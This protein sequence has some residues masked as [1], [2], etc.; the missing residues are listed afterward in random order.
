MSDGRL[1]AARTALGLVALLTAVGG[2]ARFVALGNQS[3]WV[4]ETVTA[5]LVAGSFGELLSALPT[6]ESTPPLYYLLAWG[7]ANVLGSGEAALRS[8]S[9]VL[10]TAMVPVVFAAGRELV[11]R[12]TG[13][14]AAALAAVSPLLVWY[15]QEARAYALFAFL[16]ALSLAFFARAWGTGSSRALWSWAA[17]SALAL[18]THYFAVFLVAGEAALLLYRRRQRVAYLAAGA[19]A[20]V[21]GALLPLAAY[22]A[23]HASSGW[24]RSVSM[25]LRIEETAGQLLLPSKPSIWAGAGVPEG[26]PAAWPLGLLLLA[27]AAAVALVLRRGREREGAAISLGLGVT[28]VAAPLVLALVASAAARGRGDVFLFRNVLCAWPALTIA[29]AAGLTAPRIGRFGSLLGAGLVAASAVVLGVNAATP[30]LQ[31]D[32]W[33]RVAPQAAAPGRAVVLSPSWQVAGLEHYA[34]ELVPLGGATAVDEIAV[35]SRR[36]SPSYSPTIASIAPPSPFAEVESQTI[37][38]WRLTVYRAPTA[39]RVSSER[40]GVT[41]RG[42]S[43]VILERRNS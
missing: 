13:L 10:G 25:R 17:A 21:G 7:W 16:G 20:A 43:Y 33:R 40:L 18:L 34:G 32:D 31:R 23:T 41:P 12:G 26:A 2:V 11:S 37:Q 1:A 14:L 6:S 19:V 29:V 35:V 28:A 5:E 36:W 30:H 3:F 15:S 9:A 24:I 39:L 4:D 8:L 27:G 38:N 22:Q 42:A